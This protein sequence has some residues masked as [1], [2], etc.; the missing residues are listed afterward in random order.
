VIEVDTKVG[1]VEKMNLR[2]TQLRNQHGQLITIPNGQI[3]A[4]TNHSKEWARAVLEV[5]VAYDEDPDRVIAALQQ[6]G[7]EIQQEMPD[8]VLETVEVLGVEGFKEGT[9]QIKLQL[10]TR[11]L[12]QWVVARAFRR[13]LIYRFKELGIKLPLHNKT[14][15]MAIAGEALPADEI[16]KIARQPRQP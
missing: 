11:P 8:K 2:I 9:V 3:L 6:V 15:W 12:E 1:L 13:K 5:D 10:K 7:T 4:V 16:A 14:A